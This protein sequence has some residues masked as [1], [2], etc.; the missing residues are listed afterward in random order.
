MRAQ[1]NR[2]RAENFRADGRANKASSP[3]QRAARWHMA[4]FAGPGAMLFSCRDRQH[5]ENIQTR[6]GINSCRSRRSR[7]VG[8]AFV[9]ATRNRRPAM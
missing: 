9:R 2:R 3:A 5:A 6:Q 1:L 4:A 8:Y 7:Q